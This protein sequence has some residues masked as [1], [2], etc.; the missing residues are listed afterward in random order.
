M[1]NIDIKERE[2]K[3]H[4]CLCVCVCERESMCVLS[5]A[6]RRSFVLFSFLSAQRM[7]EVGSGGK[8]L[9]FSITLKPRRQN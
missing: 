6:N 9:P 4:H 3:E 5:A 8:Q 1:Y 2:E 7:G